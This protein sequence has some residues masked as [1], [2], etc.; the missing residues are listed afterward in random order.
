MEGSLNWV[1]PFTLGF[2]GKTAC[3]GS[4]TFGVL[5]ESIATA[6]KLPRIGDRWFKNHQ[7]LQ[8]SYNRDFKPEF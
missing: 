7:L 1:I 2:D 3:V 8:S 5:E 6:T 4:L